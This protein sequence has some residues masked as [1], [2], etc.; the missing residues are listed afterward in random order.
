MYII[1]A[2]VKSVL[3]V[4]SQQYVKMRKIKKDSFQREKL[5]KAFLNAGRIITKCYIIYSEKPTDLID[6]PYINHY[7]SLKA[8][9]SKN[10]S[11]YKHLSRK[12][13]V[14]FCIFSEYCD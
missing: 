3:A 5:L 4:L 2:I 11:H 8:F 14:S 10:I 13:T 6:S 12:I 9:T 7:K 1:F